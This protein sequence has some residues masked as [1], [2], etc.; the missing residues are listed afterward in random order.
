MQNNTDG[1]HS[2]HVHTNQFQL[3][4]T[5]GVPTGPSHGWYNTVTVPVRGQIVVR[6]RF[7]DY[8]GRTVLHCHILNHE[9]AGMMSVLDI[10]PQG[11]PAGLPHGSGGHSGH[12]GHGK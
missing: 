7:L 12:G 9:N 2:F 11:V 8:T 5:N 4:S 6:T 1:Q 3:M 10:L